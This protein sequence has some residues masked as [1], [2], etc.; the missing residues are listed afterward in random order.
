MKI[1]F[2]IFLICILYAFTSSAAITNLH[3]TP[4]SEKKIAKNAIELMGELRKAKTRSGTE[5]IEAYFTPQGIEITFNRPLGNVNVY[6]KDSTG[7]LILQTSINTDIQSNLFILNQL[8]NENNFYTIQ[9]TCIYG[10]KYG[11]FEWN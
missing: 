8:F 6:I 9:F 3:K 10:E 11:T 7:K 2:T 5:F 1:R 4:E